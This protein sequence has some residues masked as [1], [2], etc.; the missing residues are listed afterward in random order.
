MTFLYYKI[1]YIGSRYVQFMNH[2]DEPYRILEKELNLSDHEMIL[3]S[4][5]KH[6]VI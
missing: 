4:I 5:P 2:N 3:S 6:S 1:G